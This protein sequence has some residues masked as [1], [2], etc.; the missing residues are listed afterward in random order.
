ML[1][2]Y[3]NKKL[4]EPKTITKTKKE[5]VEIPKTKIV[6]QQIS[7]PTQE[8]EPQKKPPILKSIKTIPPL[9]IQRSN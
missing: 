6:K 4:K 5:F 1:K 2:V 8:K 7:Q 9:P 3:E